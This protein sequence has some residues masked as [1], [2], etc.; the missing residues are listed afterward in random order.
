MNLLSSLLKYTADQIA[1]LR[2]KDTSQDTT[3][4]GINSRL[5]TAEGDI[6]SLE[7]Q[8]TTVVSAVTTDTEV[9]NI[10]FGDDGVTYDTA[11]NAV[12]KQFSDV[13]SDLTYT[14]NGTTQVTMSAYASRL[15]SY[16]DGS[17]NAHND[18]SAAKTSAD[19]VRIRI[20]IGC[21]RILFN[22]IRF[23]FS[24]TAGW[25]TYTTDTGSATSAF[26]RGGQTTY[27]DVQSGDKFFAIS[28][29]NVNGSVLTSFDIVYVY[30]TGLSENALNGSNIV[31]ETVSLIDGKYVLSTNGGVYN[32]SNYAIYE[33]H[34]IPYGCK[35]IL[36]PDV[37]YNFAGNA[38]WATYS[39]ARGASIDAYVKGG[40]TSCIEVGSSD[41][42]FAFTSYKNLSATI[43]YIMDDLAESLFDMQYPFN[44]KMIQFVG[45]S[46]TYGYDD[47][48]S[49]A[50]LTNPY[51]KLVGQQL[52][53]IVENRGISSASLMDGVMGDNT[54]T[55]VAWVN[56]YT[57]LYDGFDV[58][59]AMIG[60][61]DCYRGYT[62]GQF[63]DT[64]ADT[65]YGALHIF[66]KG[67]R[68][69]YLPEDGKHF[70]MMIYPHY[71]GRPATWD[72]FCN[73]IIEVSDYYS[74]PVLDLR[75]ECGISPYN[76][77]TYKYWRLSGGIHSAHLTQL[78]CNVVASVISKYIERMF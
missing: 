67:M 8:F 32:A 56:A 37:R 24:G 51:P 52:K 77:S 53:T 63:S 2:A 31:T 25:A 75:K 49:G 68:N 29:A 72:D 43:I 22:G 1:A 30:E 9:T 76:D 7:A 21:K 10:R 60:I 45:D 38:G 19:N 17:V 34:E 39:T 15:I 42:Y 35:K 58:V 55:P 3:V 47:D 41:K 70:F 20:P 14:G 28:S 66:I 23:N 73:A 48:N 61:N 44:E 54:P 69:K 59:G 46:V 16:E 5:I 13:K 40:R 62:L 27:I 74:V 33:K 11:G 71:E 12:R 36:L 64:T 78:G 50:Q 6:D 26:I 18:Y 57:T 4:S 65:F